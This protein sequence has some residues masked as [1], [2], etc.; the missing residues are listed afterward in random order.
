M[1]GRVCCGKRG[2]DHCAESVSVVEVVVSW[3]V[4]LV[5]L[6][7]RREERHDGA[8]C[9]FLSM[10]LLVYSTSPSPPFAGE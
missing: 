4:I 6:V 3:A 10:G 2:D 9:L 8:L 7:G 5:T 1:C